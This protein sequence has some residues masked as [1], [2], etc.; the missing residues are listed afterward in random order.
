MVKGHDQ[1]NSDQGCKIPGSFKA[2][3]VP[4]ELTGINGNQQGI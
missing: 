4:W 1:G 3:N 2:G